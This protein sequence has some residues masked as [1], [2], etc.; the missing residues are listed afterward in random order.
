[1][2]DSLNERVAKKYREYPVWIFYWWMAC[3]EHNTLKEFR[4]T[5]CD[6]D[7]WWRKKS[8]RPLIETG[9]IIDKYNT[10]K[11]RK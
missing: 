2:S 6:E 10:W 5:I 1:M 9:K 4:K 3:S 8:R 7:L 11:I